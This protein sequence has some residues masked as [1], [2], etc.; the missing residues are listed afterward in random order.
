MD[1]GLIRLC[2]CWKM[3]LSVVAQ[4][5]LYFLL[6]AA[7]CAVHAVTTITLWSKRSHWSTLEFT[8][9][10]TS[11]E[12]S[13]ELKQPF[14]HLL[15]LVWC[16]WRSWEQPPGVFRETHCSHKLWEGISLL[17]LLG[18]QWTIQFVLTTY[19]LH[20]IFV[21]FTDFAPS[22]VSLWCCVVHLCQQPG[23]CCWCYASCWSQ[24]KWK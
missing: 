14:Q 3:D 23:V 12:V 9:P 19:H 10:Q 20:F 7:L 13:N 1:Q 16:Q 22:R 18:M 21:L 15:F 17:G 6:K 4:P 5:Q 2:D 11:A 8:G 24:V